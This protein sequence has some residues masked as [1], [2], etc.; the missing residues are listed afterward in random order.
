MKKIIIRILIILVAIILVG[1]VA[2]GA[3]ISGLLYPR[4]FESGD[5]ETRIICVGDSITYGQGVI[6]SRK[7]DSFTA[8]LALEIENSTVVNY[9]LP[10]RTLLSSGNMPYAPH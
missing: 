10:N 5:G 9:G 4:A 3:F 1:A 6:G 8:R 2:I 7:T